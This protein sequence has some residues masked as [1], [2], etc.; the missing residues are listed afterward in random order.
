MK[1]IVLNGEAKDVRAAADTLGGKTVS[2]TDQVTEHLWQVLGL[3]PGKFPEGGV[4]LQL[5][6]IRKMFGML[7]ETGVAVQNYVGKTV[8]SA[9]DAI[10]YYVSIGR[11]EIAPGWLA[12]RFY[13]HASDGVYVILDAS[14]DDTKAFEK[15]GP[16]ASIQV[17]SEKPEGDSLWLRVR[18]GKVSNKDAKTVSKI[19]QD[20]FYG[21]PEK[22]V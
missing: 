20:L 18:D 14:S 21:G 4:Q 22:S 19:I 11:K 17:S 10:A 1:F 16:V 6:H 2:M 3:S 13:R 8:L 15:Y 12:N 9:P 7:E 5:T